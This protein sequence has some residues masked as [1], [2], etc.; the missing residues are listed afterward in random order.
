MALVKQDVAARWWR[1]ERR[2][3]CGRLR[4]NVP[5]GLE[6]RKRREVGISAPQ[7][8]RLEKNWEHLPG[9]SGPFILCVLQ[10]VSV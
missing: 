4:G 2:D 3:K 6:H 1:A 10:L 9:R 5:L 7:R 8:G